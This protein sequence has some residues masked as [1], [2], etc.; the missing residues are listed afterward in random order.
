MMG[1]SMQQIESQDYK[2]IE[3]GQLEADSD[4][5]SL[6]YTLDSET[7]ERKPRTKK[8]RV[9]KKSTFCADTSES[10]DKKQGGKKGKNKKNQ[11]GD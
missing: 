9:N 7:G 10:P 2:N 8:K 3:K 5:E 4:Y 11:P 6:G 1:S